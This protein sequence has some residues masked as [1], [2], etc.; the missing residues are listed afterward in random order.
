MAKFEFSTVYEVDFRL[1]VFSL[2]GALDGFNRGLYETDNFSLPGDC[3]GLTDIQLNNDLMFI[4]N[5]INGR[6]SP[7]DVIRFTTTSVKVINEQLGN[8][9]YTNAVKELQEW[10][11]A[12]DLST[13]DETTTRCSMS[14]LVQNFY[15]RIFNFTGGYYRIINLCMNFTSDDGPSVYL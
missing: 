14:T 9:G 5:F 7:Q 3:F 11:H 15:T 13:E 2:K 1:M 10:C 4:S 8:C 12:H 6:K